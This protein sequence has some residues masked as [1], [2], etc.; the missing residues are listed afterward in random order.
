M[1]WRR[2]WKCSECCDTLHEKGSKD[3]EGGDWHLEGREEKGLGSDGREGAQRLADTPPRQDLG[4]RASGSNVYPASR[5]VAFS[6]LPSKPLSYPHSVRTSLVC[7][8]CLGGVL[9]ESERNLALFAQQCHGCDT[10]TAVLWPRGNEDVGR[11]AGWPEECDALDVFW[12]LRVR[13]GLSLVA[14]WRLQP[15]HLNFKGKFDAW[16]PTTWEYLGY[17]YFGIYWAASGHYYSVFFNNTVF[18]LEAACASLCFHLCLCWWQPG[19]RKKSFLSWASQ[20]I[21]S[22]QI[23]FWAWNGWLFTFIYFSHIFS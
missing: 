5:S 15:V 8:L 20:E 21:P 14:G 22:V 2:G 12:C 19:K 6:V 23:R 18:F 17:V 9:E 7:S 3:L 11:Q 4:L 10:R 16:S 13:R 1:V